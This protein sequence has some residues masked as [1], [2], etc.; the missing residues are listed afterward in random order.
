MAATVRRPR[1]LLLA[2]SLWAGCGTPETDFAVQV[3]SEVDRIW[4]GPDFYANRLQDWRVQNGRIESVEGSAAGRC[5]YSHV[6]WES[7]PV[8]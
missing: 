2:V 4:V 1:F 5:I 6:L 3:S 7:R 8:P